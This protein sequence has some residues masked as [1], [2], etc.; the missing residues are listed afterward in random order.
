MRVN[1]ERCPLWLFETSAF[2]TSIFRLATTVIIRFPHLSRDCSVRANAAL[3][4]VVELQ[5]SMTHIP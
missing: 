2:S 3:R 4:K 5:G 1:F